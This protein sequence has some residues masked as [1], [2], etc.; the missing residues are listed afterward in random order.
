MP[1]IVLVVYCKVSQCIIMAVH[2]VSELPDK[3]QAMCTVH[4]SKIICTWIC[5]AH[6]GYF[7][8]APPTVCALR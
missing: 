8:R 2:C 3:M 5:I 4:C 1:G 6:V 7:T